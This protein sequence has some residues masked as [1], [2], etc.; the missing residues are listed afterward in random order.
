MTNQS[1]EVVFQGSETKSLD[2]E[3]RGVKMLIKVRDLSWSERNKILGKCFIY[4]TDGNISF[5]F[6]RYMKDMLSKM[7][8]EAPWGETNDLFFAQVSREFGSIL[9]KIVPKAFE[10]AQLPDFFVSGQKPSSKE[11]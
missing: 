4:Q 8:I 6:D 7:V 3:Y 5:D 9:E 10:E 11:Q 1:W 2:L